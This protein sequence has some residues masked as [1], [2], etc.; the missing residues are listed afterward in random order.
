M[1]SQGR[2]MCPCVTAW[3]LHQTP[4]IRTGLG[5]M[6]TFEYPKIAILFCPM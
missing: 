1:L 3:K 2:L 5:A 6:E 4:G